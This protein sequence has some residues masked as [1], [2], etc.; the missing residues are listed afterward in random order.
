[1]L[2]YQH[3]DVTHCLK[4]LDTQYA[5]GLQLR[6]YRIAVQD[7]TLSIPINR[8]KKHPLTDQDVRHILRDV[9]DECRTDLPINKYPFYIT[10]DSINVSLV[11]K[12][13]KI[14]LLKYFKHILNGKEHGENLRTN[15][16]ICYPKSITVDYISI[17]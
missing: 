13:D 6:Q 17:R 10:E 7:Y 4:T 1:M 16:K 8:T 9:F 12:G 11:R 5:I 15:L 2:Q 3:G 14:L